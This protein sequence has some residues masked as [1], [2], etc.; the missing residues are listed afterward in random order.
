MPPK[1]D[2]PLR[3]YIS[4]SEKSIGCL[5]AQNNDREMEQAVYYLSRVLNETEQRYS[6]I[7]KLCLTLHFACSKLRHYL[8]GVTTFVISQTDVIK[9]MLSRPIIT[10]RI[11]KWALGLAEFTLCYVPQRAVKGQALADFLADH[12]C[13]DIEKEVDLEIGV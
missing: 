13:L 4:A 5:L 8:I 7:E 3:L 2:S 9:Y 10:C 11:G 1:K 6:R 12:P